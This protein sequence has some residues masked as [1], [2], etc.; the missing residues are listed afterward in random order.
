M[1]LCAY[2]FSF[3]VWA[4]EPSIRLVFVGDVMLADG[5][6]QVIERGEDPFDPFADILQ[7]ADFTIGNLECVIATRGEEVDKPWTFRAHPRTLSVLTKHFDAVSLANNHTGDFGHE[8]FLEQLD[9]LKAAKLSK[10][11]GGRNRAEAHRPLIV[12]SQGIRIAFL[13]YNEFKPR[14]FEAGETTPGVAWSVDEQ[15]LADIA[16][17][18]V[19]DRADLVIPMMHWG[20]E[21]E[22]V[23]DERQKALAH[24]MID[25]G[26]DV[27]VGGHPHCTQGTEIYKNKLIVYSLGN[28]VFDGF[29]EPEAKLGWVLRLTLNRRR[30]VQWDIIEAEIDA[31]GVPRPKLPPRNSNQPGCTPGAREKLSGLVPRPKVITLTNGSQ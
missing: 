13:G 4:A 19:N 1:F 23:P 28:F 9:L 2:S 27:V 18:R 25:A 10:F 26:A 5:P 16:S 31:A 24:K 11:G 14:S 15:V 7:S 17:A 6:G 22:P 20:S 12:E 21:Y 8:A 30:L 3:R 29:T